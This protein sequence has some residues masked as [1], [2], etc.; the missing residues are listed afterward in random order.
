MSNGNTSPHDA[1]IQA[2]LQ[3]YVGKQVGR[4]LPVAVAL[5]LVVAMIVRAPTVT[6]RDQQRV[7][8]AGAGTSGATSASDDLAT[9]DGAA[10]AAVGEGAPADPA[11]TTGG[12]S[13]P[14]EASAGAAAGGAGG[15][16]SGSQPSGGTGTG[17]VATS[18]PNGVSKTGIQCGPGVRQFTWSKYAPPCVPAF[19]GDNGGDTAP[20]VTKDTITVTYRKTTSPS[21]A[22]INA[23]SPNA[24]A[25]DP[26]TIADTQRY[27]DLFNKNFELYGRKV[28]LKVYDGQSD[29]LLEIQGQ[30][31]SQAQGDAVRA[32]EQ[33]AFAD[34]TGLSTQIYAE[35]LVDQK[36]VSTGGI[37][38]SQKWLTDHAPF[39]YESWFPTGDNAAYAAVGLVCQRLKDL[40]AIDS[41]DEVTKTQKRVFGIVTPEN[42]VYSAAGDI[43]ERGLKE[44][45]APIGRRIKY[46][47]NIATASQQAASAVAQLK[48]AGVTTVVCGCDPIGPVFFAQAANQQQYYPE[49]DTLWWGDVS[50]RSVDSAQ[51]SHSISIGTAGEVPPKDQLEAY[52]AMKMAGAE[53]AEPNYSVPYYNV[54][55]LFMGLHAAGPKLTPES[56]QRGIF[57][58]P[59]TE[60]GDTG[61]WS[62]GKGA[63]SPHTS[64]VVSYWDPNLVSK[65]DGQKG[66]YVACEGGKRFPFRDPNALGPRGH[67]RC[68]GRK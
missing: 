2:A 46:A 24:I 36:I 40:P 64:F 33:G 12:A 25:P 42:P 11:S 39:A 32:K 20:G 23:A 9:A 63:Y 62:F 54:L 47:L 30:N 35:A 67:L 41:G 1:E 27:I 5:C 51:W 29:P 10:D 57:S 34:V 19:K 56:L 6:E 60:D 44:C 21:S 13:A 26:E 66:G 14:T 65:F 68:F 37:Y 48:A 38:M 55:H 31:Q 28:V 8:A 7:N 59:K 3:Q 17:A 16:R 53:P 22:A 18:A 49:W 61:L 52:R 45:G 4:Y 43:M 58:L 15:A 50:Q